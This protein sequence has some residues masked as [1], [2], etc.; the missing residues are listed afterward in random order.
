MAS[1]YKFW[2]KPALATSRKER[3]LTQL[4]I[5]DALAIVLKR[6][7]SQNSYRMWEKSQRPVTLEIAQAIAQLIAKPLGEL[8]ETR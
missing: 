6:G 7:I 8:W 3:K 2:A 4:D 1:E 5:S